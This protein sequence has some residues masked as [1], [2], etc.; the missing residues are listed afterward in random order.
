M[1]NRLEWLLE[2]LSW[3]S[4]IH[5]KWKE[6]GQGFWRP[7]FIGMGG[8]G[9]IAIAFNQ[10]IVSPVPD[11]GGR[12]FLI[13]CSLLD[14]VAIIDGCQKGEIRN[15]ESG[16]LI[17]EGMPW[18]KTAEQINFPYDKALEV[19]QIG[20]MAVGHNKALRQ[21]IILQLGLEEKPQETLDVRTLEVS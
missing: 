21:E 15:G 17:A 14:A 4:Y 19:L 10:N 18:Q 2:R 6:T 20:S 12:L 3:A 8:I 16:L 5:E 9:P 13:P 1:R 7:G 11:I